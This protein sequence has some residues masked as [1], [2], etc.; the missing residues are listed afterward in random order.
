MAWLVALKWTICF[1]YKQGPKMDPTKFKNGLPSQ[2]H[3]EGHKPS[4]FIC[5]VKRA[6]KKDARVM[7]IA[8]ACS[9]NHSG[10]FSDAFFRARCRRMVRF[11]RIG[12]FPAPTRLSERFYEKKVQYLLFRI[13]RRKQGPKMDPTKFQKCPLS[14]TGAGNG[15]YQV[16]K[17][18]PLTGPF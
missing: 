7:Q 10:P 5:Q 11:F 14:Q 9:E 8:A 18:S 13:A 17:Q 6:M 16:Q 15:P 12:C 1:Q 2:V 3:F 4:H